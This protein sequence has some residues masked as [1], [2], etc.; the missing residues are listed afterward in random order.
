MLVIIPVSISVILISV[1]IITTIIIVIII[2]IV[3]IIRQTLP[4]DIVIRLAFKIAVHVF[5]QVRVHGG[6]QQSHSGAALVAL[7]D[8]A[9][10]E[11]L[12]ENYL[13]DYK[14][15]DQFWNWFKRRMG[16]NIEADWF[17]NRKS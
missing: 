4:R 7:R 6:P 8:I 10:G 17:D 9:I 15:E 16:L 12:L 13:L 3:I 2:V 1:N 11:E 14:E 5:I